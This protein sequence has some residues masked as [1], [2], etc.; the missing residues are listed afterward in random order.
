MSSIIGFTATDALRKELE[1]DA[2]REGRS[3]SNFVLMLVLQARA[4]RARAEA[5]DAVAEMRRG[6]LAAAGTAT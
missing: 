6:T 2:R 4:A 3:L 1:A 5:D